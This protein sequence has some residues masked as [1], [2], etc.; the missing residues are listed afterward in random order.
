[1]S[2]FEA[3]SDIDGFSCSDS[4]AGVDDSFRWVSRAELEGVEEF[5]ENSLEELFS[6]GVLEASRAD[7]LSETEELVGMSLVCDMVK[8]PSLVFEAGAGFSWQAAKVRRDR[9][10]IAPSKVLRYIIHKPP[11]NYLYLC[12][13]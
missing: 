2:V 8:E 11:K 9:K 12:G 3:E 5:D 13:C 1:M 10:N 4:E 7:I 6:D